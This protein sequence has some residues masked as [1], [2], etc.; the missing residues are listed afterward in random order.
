MI[1]VVIAKVFDIAWL[2]ADKSTHEDPWNEAEE[3][4]RRDR[5]QVSWKP[6][7]TRSAPDEQERYLSEISRLNEEMQAGLEPLRSLAET[8]SSSADGI[9]TAAGGCSRPRASM[10]DLTSRVTTR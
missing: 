6:I 5:W 2:N 1:D 10:S 3:A 4:V 7:D 9:E 8:L